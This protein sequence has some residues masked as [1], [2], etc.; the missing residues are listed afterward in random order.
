MLI[1]DKATL[2]KSL[3]NIPTKT[4]ILK[5]SQA[6]LLSLICVDNYY[7]LEERFIQTNNNDGCIS[8]S[9]YVDVRYDFTKDLKK[10]LKLKTSEIKLGYNTCVM[11]K[12][13]GDILT[14]SLEPVKEIALKLY[15]IIRDSSIYPHITTLDMNMIP[16]KLDTPFDFDV[17]H[18]DGVTLNSRMLSML[19]KQFDYC[20]VGRRKDGMLRF[21]NDTKD[22]YMR[23][24]VECT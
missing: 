24:A 6:F 16:E 5:I 11:S 21:F 2:Y 13:K 20:E 14:Y 12:P 9:A 23:E 19:H 15:S 4:Y 17:I 3:V 7:I 8:M 10:Y 1:T 18:V 22:L